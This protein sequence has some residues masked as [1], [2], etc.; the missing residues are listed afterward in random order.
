MH[1]TACTSAGLHSDCSLHATQSVVLSDFSLTACTQV[2]C[3]RSA[4][5]TSACSACTSGDSRQ[6]PTALQ[7]LYLVVSAC[8]RSAVTDTRYHVRADSIVLAVVVVVRRRSAEPLNGNGGHEA[9]ELEGLVAPRSRG[10]SRAREGAGQGAH[11]GRQSAVVSAPDAPRASA[12]K[13]RES[14]RLPL[15]TSGAAV[16]R[17]TLTGFP[18]TAVRQVGLVLSDEGREKDCSC[19]GTSGALCLGRAE[20]YC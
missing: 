7:L 4:C 17:G 13:S 8:R 14:G 5:R 20:I 18:R 2:Q 11:S 9:P 1:S 12:E 10:S 15:L 19:A 16:R 3:K 6:N